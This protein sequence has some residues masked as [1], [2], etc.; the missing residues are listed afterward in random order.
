MSGCW[1]DVTTLRKWWGGAG[2]GNASQGSGPGLTR[3][4]GVFPHCA[5]PCR[6][7]VGHLDPSPEAQQ[8]QGQGQGHCSLS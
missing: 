4:T 6:T 1:D 3:V 2:R 8:R 7:P 5:Q